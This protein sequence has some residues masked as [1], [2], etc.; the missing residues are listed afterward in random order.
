MIRLKRHIRHLPVVSVIPLVDV[1]LILLVFFMVTS[2]FL[3]LDMLP[4]SQAEGTGTPAEGQARA[5]VVRILPGGD[6]ASGGQRVEPEGISGF[7]AAQTEDNI[8]ILLL[9]SPDADV[10]ALTRVLDA[11][12]ER[13]I[14]SLRVLQL[15]DGER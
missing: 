2:T 1:L 10:Q 8:Q 13:G 14:G 9:P 7:F 6:L 15:S 11:A 5:V 3:D 12:A 4:M